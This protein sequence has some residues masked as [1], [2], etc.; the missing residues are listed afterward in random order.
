MTE[1][2]AT[3][4]LDI[5]LHYSGD[6]EEGEPM[7]RDDPGVAPFVDS[8]WLDDATLDG[9]SIFANTDPNDPAVRQIKANLMLTRYKE[10][11]QNLL[12]TYERW[13]P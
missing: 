8:L 9:V 12:D 1:T 11:E 5:E 6:I 4:D 7:T 13:L 10:L 3:Y 2:S